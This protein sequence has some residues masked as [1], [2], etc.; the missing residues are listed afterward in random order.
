MAFG[1]FAMADVGAARRFAQ[2]SFSERPDPAGSL[3]DIDSQWYGENVRERVVAQSCMARVAP[4]DEEDDPIKR[5]LSKFILSSSFQQ[6]MM[7]P[8]VRALIRATD[9]L[10]GYSPRFKLDM[11]VIDRPHYAYCMLKA[12]ELA[13][14]L[15]H[16]RI[17]AIE[18]GVAGG[19]GL[20]FMCDF[21]P[22]VERATGVGVDCYGFDTGAGMPDPEGVEDLP[23][24]FRA[25]QYKMDVDAL[26]KRV[27]TAHLVLGNIR[28]SIGEFVSRYKPAPIG[29]IFNDTDYWS[30]TLES[31]RLFDQAAAHPE[32]FLP[33]QFLYFDDI[34]GSETEMYGPFNGQ[35]LAID[36]YNARQD[37]VKIH[38]NQNLRRFDHLPY[39]WQIYY[40]HLVGHPD[41][42][43]Y[44]GG[45]RQEELERALRLSSEA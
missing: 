38:L 9:G 5:F 19:N 44:V 2:T 10:Y 3:D 1:C 15:G 39:R 36:Q 22:E 43:R 14:R 30:S 26:K 42:S 16:K 32:N 35:L 24:W 31:F 28:D 25:Q 29:A 33:R 17:S 11:L 13:K 6:S 45:Q 20:A 34:L 23:Y 21:A 37:A 41:Y 12:A 7:A 4:D 18:F 27:P 40:A 8:A